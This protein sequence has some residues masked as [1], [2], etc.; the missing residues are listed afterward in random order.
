MHT[1]TTSKK[2]D[3]AIAC[4]QF[5]AEV[6]GK[7]P[8]L[9][10][11]P[12]KR[13]IPNKA[14]RTKSPYIMLVGFGLILTDA[15]HPSVVLSTIL[16]RADIPSH[17][18]QPFMSLSCF[19]PNPLPA[20]L[21]SLSS[22]IGNPRLGDPCYFNDEHGPVRPMETLSSLARASPT[23]SSSTPPQLLASRN[24]YDHAESSSDDDVC[25]TA[26][27][28]F[29]HIDLDLNRI[30]IEPL[31][32]FRTASPCLSSPP[33]K[34]E[35]SAKQEDCIMMN[36]HSKIKQQEEE[37]NNS[38]ESPAA[39]GRRWTDRYDELVTY[40]RRF[41]TC[42]VPSQWVENPPLAQWVKRQRYQLRLR[43]EGERSTMSS[44]REELL[45]QLDFTWDPHSAFWEE[46]LIVLEKFLETHGHANVPT[47]YP[48]NPQLAIWAK[49]SHREE[50]SQ[51]FKQETD[52]SCS[53]HPDPFCYSYYSANVDK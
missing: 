43:N 16:R 12:I 6:L 40:K 53:H 18:L 35:E 51:L 2:L 26:G 31:R 25:W 17:K 39:S 7:V 28:Q 14:Q 29:Q 49:V 19:E 36:K 21:F 46:R 10:E 4:S 24:Y 38:C 15:H 50:T 47:K 30:K 9:S 32:S 48:E 1:G 8:V 13:H 23:T 33:R 27:A 37:K 3:G 5:L 44:E 41:G 11:L 45:N 34:N 22:S 42:C 52:F 20:S